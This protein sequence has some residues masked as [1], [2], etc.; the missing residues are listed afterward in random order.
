VIYLIDASVYVFR[1][2]HSML[3]DMTDRDGNASHAV[4]GF[5]KFL[6][7]LVE[8]V[9]PEYIAV[10]FDKSLVSCFRSRI[11]PAYKKNR[12]P[13]PVDL[14]LQFERCFEFC[15]H[16]G[17]A[18]FG[19]HDYE[20]DDIIGSLVH[21]ARRVGLKATVVSRDKDLAQLIREGDIYWDYTSRER[22]GYPDIEKRFGVAPERFADYLALMGDAVDNI[23]GVPGIGAKTA[24]VLMREFASL[25]ELYEG[26]SRVAL[27]KCRGA[28]SLAAKLLE[29]REAAYLARQLTVIACDVPM[30]IES[31]HLRRRLPDVHALT[32]FYD[33]HRFGP[34]LRNQTAR[35]TQLPLD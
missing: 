8:R 34:M 9:R 11:Y 1:A 28:S 35:I 12:E 29:H 23:P 6:S 18:A 20:A 5:A 19:S 24:A 3:P 32:A 17:V 26:L 2:Y 4:F 16:L 25:D 15:K 7:D 14:A 13:P 33:H 30:E 31:E 21:R 27:L 22:F 10:A